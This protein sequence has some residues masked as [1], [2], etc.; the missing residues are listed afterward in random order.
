M[1]SAFRPDAFRAAFIGSGSIGSVIATLIVLFKLKIG[2]TLY[3]L[4]ILSGIM[5]NT[6][7][8]TSKWPNSTLGMCSC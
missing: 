6:D 1:G 3:S 5:P 2:N 8:S 7:F 4:T